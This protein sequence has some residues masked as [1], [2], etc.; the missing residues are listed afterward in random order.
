MGEGAEGKGEEVAVPGGSLEQA[1]EK[2]PFNFRK[3]A[4]IGKK[5]SIFL[6]SVNNWLFLSR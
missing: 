1:G 4:D 5:K 6:F 3:P 2:R